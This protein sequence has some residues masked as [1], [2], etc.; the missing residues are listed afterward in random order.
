MTL[1]TP[2]TFARATDR[3][4]RHMG[5]EGDVMMCDR[6]HRVITDGAVMLG[7]D[8]RLVLCKDCADDLARKIN[9]QRQP[10]TA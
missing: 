8:H 9:T 6:C 10:E 3:A 1:P 4:W 7:A 2:G 5:C